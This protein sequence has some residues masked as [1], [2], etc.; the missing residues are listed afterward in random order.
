[1]AQL[2]DLEIAGVDLLFKGDKFVL[3]EVNGSPGF[4]EFESSCDVNVAGAIA[5]HITAQLRS[6]PSLRNH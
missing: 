1:M 5:K 3:V 6:P 4:K 2:L